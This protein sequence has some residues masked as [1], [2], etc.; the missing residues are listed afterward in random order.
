MEIIYHI[1]GLAL[2]FGIAYLLLR[3]QSALRLTELTSLKNVAEHKANDLLSRKQELENVTEQQQQ[4]ILTLTSEFSTAKNQLE[5]LEKQLQVQKTEFEELQKQFAKEFE[6]L[7]NRIFEEKGKLFAEQNKS[8]LDQLLKPFREN[9]KDFEKKVGEAY[10]KELRDKISLREEVRKLYDLNTKISQEANNLT[11]ALKGDTKKQGNWGETILEKILERSG[12]KK[13]VE[14][15]TQ[16]VTTNQSGE[17]IRPDVT[18][19]LPD[20][21]HI[22]IDAK[23]SL[24]AYERFV[25]ADEEEERKSYLHDHLNSVR[26]HIKLLSDKNYFTAKNMQSPDFI[27][28]FTPIESSFSL[29]MQND[30]ELFNFAWEKRIVIVSPTTLLAT[31]MTVSSLWKIESQNKFAMEIARLSGAMYDKLE[32]VIAELIKVGKSIQSTDE[33]YRSAM[34]KLYEGSGNVIKT[35]EKIKALGAKA[36][37][38]LP[39]SIIDRAED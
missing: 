6:N 36:S 10:D 14:Y 27:L 29:A 39:Q 16:I 35:A 30:P 9:I 24:V 18:V 13:G 11:K 3:N 23:V 1:T 33:Q 37:K 26:S 7:A 2:G 32:G 20:N 4:K 22:I 28:L 25:N 38:S 12:L 17:T 34:S 8:N 5:N 15:Q 31:L 21:K 19:L